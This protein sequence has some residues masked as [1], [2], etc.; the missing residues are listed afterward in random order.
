[1]PSESHHY[2]NCRN[3]DRSE[4]CERCENLVNAAGV[5]DDI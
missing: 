2:T 5:H 4:G 1:M 3:C